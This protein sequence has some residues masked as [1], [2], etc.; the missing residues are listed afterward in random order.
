MPIKVA[1]EAGMG[2]RINT[3]MQTCFFALSGVLPREERSLP[4]NKPSARPTA[5]RAK[6][7]SP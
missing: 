7:L 6:K 2:N 5:R 3:V 4:S 1:K